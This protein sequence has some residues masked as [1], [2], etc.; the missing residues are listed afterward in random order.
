MITRPNT[1]IKIFV[2]N[3]PGN[4]MKYTT[5][6]YSLIF[7]SLYCTI[8]SIVTRIVSDMTLLLSDAPCQSVQQVESDGCR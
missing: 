6:I 4:C 3:G 5:V 1:N 7:E 2:I 8:G